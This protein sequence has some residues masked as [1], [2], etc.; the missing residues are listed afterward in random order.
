[1]GRPILIGRTNKAIII[2]IIIIIFTYKLSKP[3][4][5]DVAWKL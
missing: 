4:S 2:I 3:R 5:H 1:M